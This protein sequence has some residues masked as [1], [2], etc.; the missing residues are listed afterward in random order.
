MHVVDGVRG[1]RL[2]SGSGGLLLCRDVRESWEELSLW[3][4][5]VQMVYL[6][7]PFGTGQRFALRQK[8]GG[9]GYRG[10]GKHT[11]TLP[12]YADRMNR[13][14]YLLLLRRAVEKA[15]EMLCDDGSLFV[16]VDW[17]YSAHVRLLLDDVFGEACFMNEIIWHYGSGG[18]SLQHFSRKHD[19]IFFYGKT[20]KPY[21]NPLPLGKPRGSEARNHLR[22]RTDEDGRVF[23]SIRTAGKEYRYYEDDPIYPDDVWEDISH[24]QQ[25]DPERTGYA[26]QKPELLLERLIV[27]TS[28]EGDCVA[29]FFGGSGTTAA[30]AQRTNRTFIHVDSAML[31]LHTARE[32]LLGQPDF[33]LL[34]P[35]GAEAQHEVALTPKKQDG[36]PGVALQDCRLAGME[37]WRER[38]TLLP[39]VPLVW[40]WAVGTVEKGMLRV[41]AYASRSAEEPE[42]LLW[43]PWPPSG[44]AVVQVVDVCGGMRFYRVDQDTI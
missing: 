17:R 30:V 11:V 12:V 9:E 7:P 40:Y 21:F 41:H 19:T 22:R 37:P 5:R 44:E 26:T 6:D 2:G 28:R 33:T 8:I 43:L 39:D 27:A 15:H 34:Y 18:R 10:D 14:D 1:E 13:E 4:G 36:V 16:H 25:K 23:F 20:A 35:R 31:S 3:K 29:D 42:L 32:R 24:L 38:A